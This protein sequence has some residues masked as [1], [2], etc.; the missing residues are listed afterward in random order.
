VFVLSFLLR[1]SASFAQSV[2]SS[3]L[4]PFHR[5][6]KRCGVILPRR[7]PAHEVSDLPR[8]RCS[9][10]VSLGSTLTI[11]VRAVLPRTRGNNGISGLILEQQFGWGVWCQDLV[12]DMFADGATEVRY[13]MTALF[14]VVRG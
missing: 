11:R 5:L 2:R 4:L 14:D 6:L 13:G 3:L 12:P 9:P 1:V 7:V 10:I 8:C